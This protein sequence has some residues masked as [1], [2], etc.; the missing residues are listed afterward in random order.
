MSRSCAGHDGVHHLSLGGAGGPR[1]RSGSTGCAGCQRAR[2]LRRHAGRHRRQRGP[3]LDP[4]RSGRRAGR[5]AVGRDGYTLMFAALLLT[6]GALTD[7]WGARTA[8][9]IGVAVFVLA[10]VACA[11]APTVAVLVAARFVQG[12]GAAVAM[13]ASMALVR[14]SY[15]EPARRARAIGIWSIGAAVAAASGPVIGGLLSL[16]SWR[17]IFVLNVPVGI[18]TLLLL[19]RAPR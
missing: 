4:G 14:T 3:A 8:L 5:A 7:R 19:A 10:S 9:G 15:D 17:L 1:G 13:P 12:A 2:F 16:T 11:L 18:V 6:A